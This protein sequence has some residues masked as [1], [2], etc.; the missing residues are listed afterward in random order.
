[1][2]VAPTPPPSGDWHTPEY[3]PGSG[4]GWQPGRGAEPDRRGRGG[5]A[6]GCRW[7]HFRRSQSHRDQSIDRSLSFPKPQR[8]REGEITG[9]PPR[10]QRPVKICFIFISSQVSPRCPLEDPV[11]FGASSAWLS[12]AHPCPPLPALNGPAALP[13]VL[14]RKC[15]KVA[16]VRNEPAKAQS[17]LS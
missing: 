5:E 9:R 6:V 13:A 11:R 10:R 16:G 17:S 15:Q 8:I 2:W 14:I 1:M 7:D 3:P 12:S 4:A